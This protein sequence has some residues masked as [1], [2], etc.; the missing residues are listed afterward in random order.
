[1]LLQSALFVSVLLFAAITIPT[2]SAQEV[3]E[4][5]TFENIEGVAIHARQK[6]NLLIRNCIFDN[7]GVAIR[8]DDC[9]NV[10][11][12]SCLIKN[13]TIQGIDIRGGCSDIRVRGNILEGFRD[14][15]QGGHLIATQKTK[16]PEQH[17]IFIVDN[18]LWGNGK[19]WVEGRL[20]GAC[21]DML[22]LRSITDFR[23]TGNSLSGGGEF[24]LT[25]LYGSENGIIAHNTIKNVDGTGLL[26]GYEVKNINVNSNNIV[27]VGCSFETDGSKN[28]ISHQAGIHCRNGVENVLITSNLIARETSEEMRYAINLRETSGVIKGNLIRGIRKPLHIPRAVA[29]SVDVETDITSK[30]E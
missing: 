14:D 1:M 30:E 2:G 9:H 20:D 15:V 24:G 21:G 12:E 7:V 26:L 3:I 27:D 10:T 16:T 28:D 18:T 6:S 17:R 19:S 23:A 25:C 8:L 4:N 13:L 22:S 5:K 11:I 29:D